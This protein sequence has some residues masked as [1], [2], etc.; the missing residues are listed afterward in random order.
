MAS[1]PAVACTASIHEQ[2]KDWLQCIS[3]SSNYLCSL[4]RISLVR[5]E[6]VHSA[7]YSDAAGDFPVSLLTKVPPILESASLNAW[8]MEIGAR[9]LLL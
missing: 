2:E 8:R 7:M 9:I 3:C 4:A 5:Y 1:V 6:Q